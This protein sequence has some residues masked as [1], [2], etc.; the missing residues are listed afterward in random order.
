[1]E[2]QAGPHSKPATLIHGRMWELYSHFLYK[3]D[4]LLTNGKR[5]TWVP[6]KSDLISYLD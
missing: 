5:R 4:H 3:V 1:M 2:M 6:L